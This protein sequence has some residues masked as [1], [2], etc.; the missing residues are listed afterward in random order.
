MAD[1]AWSKDRVIE[2]SILIN[3]P[4]STVLQTIKDFPSYPTWSSFITSIE[5]ASTGPSVGS[6]LKV[7]LSPP[8]G[9]GMTMTPTVVLNDSTGFGW[10]GHLANINGIFDGKHLFLVSEEGAG[11]TR[12]VQREE[13]A[14]FLYAPLM[15]WLGMGAKTK[16]GFELY[17]EA[18]KRR[19]E[20]VQGSAQ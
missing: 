14:G 3:A 17:N 18:V 13:F 1:P 8:G 19:A 11:K 20:E 15:N 16:A 5:S 12:L 6:T 2:T 9:S 10:H 7:N 4:P